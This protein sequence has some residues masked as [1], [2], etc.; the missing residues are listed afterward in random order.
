MRGLCEVMVAQVGTWA[1]WLELG[2]C[3][4]REVF[5]G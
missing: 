2:D 4:V 3:V 1:L 5:D